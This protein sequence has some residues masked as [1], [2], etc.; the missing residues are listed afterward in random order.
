MALTKCE[1]CKGKISEQAT[2]CPHCGH[3]QAEKPKVEPAQPAPPAR[4]TPSEAAN[5]SRMMLIIAAIAVGG[6][7]LWYAQRPP[8]P[9]RKEA[10]D[11]LVAGIAMQAAA[12]GSK[13]WNDA[14]VRSIER[15]TPV[16]GRPCAT[17]IYRYRDS[18]GSDDPRCN[19]MGFIHPETIDHEVVLCKFPNGWRF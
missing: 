16:D 19:Q 4:P 12:G 14:V 1:A 17:I 18:T 3:P 7:L 2:T 9:T 6:F 10:H 8:V 11:G 5:Q 15:N 13:C